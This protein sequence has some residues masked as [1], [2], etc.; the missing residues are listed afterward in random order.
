MYRIYRIQSGGWK[1]LYSTTSFERARYLS[2]E[3]RNR[4]PHHQYKVFFLEE[5]KAQQQDLVPAYT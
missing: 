5:N 2:T 3:L 1:L 4:Y